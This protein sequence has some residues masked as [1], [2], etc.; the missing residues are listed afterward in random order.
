MAPP[1]LF[2]FIFKGVIGTERFLNA[3]IL[4]RSLGLGEELWLQLVVEAWKIEMMSHLLEIAEVRRMI[5]R[6]TL[7][8]RI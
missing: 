6:L 2:L 7:V 4:P 1:V 3:F 5:T 8:V